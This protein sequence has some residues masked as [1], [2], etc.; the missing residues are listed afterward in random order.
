MS[1]R[2]IVSI[3]F[4]IIRL[5]G[6]LIVLWLILSWHVWKARG[7]FEKQLVLQGMRKEDARMMGAKYSKLKGDIL[8]TIRTGLR[9]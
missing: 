5:L 3:T 8:G 9:T 6:S 1:V 2:S 4:F 7:A